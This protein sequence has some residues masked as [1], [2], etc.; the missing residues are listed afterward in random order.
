MIRVLQVI[1]TLKRAG[2]E[3]LVD[4]LVRRLDRRRFEPAIAALYDATS[5]EYDPPVRTWRLGKQRGFDARM[6]S[7]LRDVMDEFRPDIVHTHSY[8]MRYTLPVARCKQVHTVHNLAR[9][10]VDW[11]GRMIH[12]VGFRLGVKPVAVAESVARSFEDEYGFRPV[13]IPNG[14]D[15]SRF[16]R[17]EAREAWRRANGFGPEQT[18]IVCVA[19]LEPQKNPLALV[20]ALPSGC[21]LL[22]AGD[23]SLRGELEGIDHVHLLG[24][25]TDLPELLA[26][27]DVFA[28]ASQWEGHPLAVMEAMA[29]GLPVV[30]TAVGGVPEI[31]GEA[32]LLC[33]PMQL[34]DALRAALQ[35]RH[36]LAAAALARAQ[37]FD[38]CRTV[39]RYAE[40][41]EQI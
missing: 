41:F 3:T 30:A 14:I 16:H 40:L 24:V 29:A 33:P 23:G 9:K 25:R 8:V 28:I 2:A 35:R 15:V 7:R 27:C 12:R 22:L 31:V 11:P 18:L 13:V 17:P 20:R 37:S 36:Q 38:I 26:A 10:E 1:A 5:Q 19:R 32:G 6:F 4:S 21:E 39:Q 34:D